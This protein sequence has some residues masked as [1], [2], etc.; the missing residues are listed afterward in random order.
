MR[1]EADQGLGKGS[2]PAF[3]LKLWKLVDD[4]AYDSIISWSQVR[5]KYF[6]FVSQPERNYPL[7]CVSD[8]FARNVHS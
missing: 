6:S 5:F 8:L 7:G 4:P 3:L 2:V 1:V